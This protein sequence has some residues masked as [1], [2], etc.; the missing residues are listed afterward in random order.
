MVAPDL[1]TDF[2]VVALLDPDTLLPY[3][4]ASSPKL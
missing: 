4:S 3:F 1:T 2:V